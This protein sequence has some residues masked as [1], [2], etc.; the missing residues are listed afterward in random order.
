ME[1]GGL[2][3]AGGWGIVPGVWAPRAGLDSPSF[4]AAVFCLLCFSWILE[5]D[6]W[7][8]WAATRELALPV[9]QLR[10][11]LLLRLFVFRPSPDTVVCSLLGK[12]QM[13]IFLNPIRIAFY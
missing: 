8:G 3:G 1:T 10:H 7:K 5:M 6:G 4:V 9:C 13:M 11:L 12:V 2:A